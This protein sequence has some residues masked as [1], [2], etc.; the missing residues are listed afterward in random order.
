MKVLNKTLSLAFFTCLYVQAKAQEISV[1]AGQSSDNKFTQ[2]EPAKFV[3][4][5]PADKTAKDSYAANGYLGLNFDIT[6]SATTLSLTGELQK[7]TLLAKQQDVQQYGIKVA[8]IVPFTGTLANPGLAMYVDASA[9]YSRD[10][11]KDKK[12][13]QLILAFYFDNSNAAEGFKNYLR[14]NTIHPGADSWVKDILQ[15]RW[16]HSLGI[17]HIGYESLTMGNATLGVEVFPFSGL[18]HKAFNKYDLIQLKWSIVD[19]FKIGSST[20]ALYTGTLKTYGAGLNIMFDE[21][22]TNALTIGYEHVDGGNP[23][24]GLD[25]QKYGQL[26][27]GAKVKF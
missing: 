4:T 19:R 12:G 26:A 25:D 7:N 1:S 20:S 2:S 3:A 21:D 27:I 6:S 16:T 24:K 18:L 14:P 15:Y 9:K 17:E 22:G 10:R 5:F 13:A 11:V 8:Q 23:M